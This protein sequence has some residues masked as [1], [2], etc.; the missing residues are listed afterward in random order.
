MGVGW[1]EVAVVV[2]IAQCDLEQRPLKRM[3]YC[4]EREQQS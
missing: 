4:F 2:G 3:I 1:G